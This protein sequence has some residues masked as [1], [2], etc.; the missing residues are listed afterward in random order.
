MLIASA[1]VQVKRPGNFRGAQAGGV[2]R[3]LL[4]VEH[5]IAAVAKKLHQIRQ[6]HFRSV[7]LAEKHRFRGE[8][9][10]DAHA[11]GATAKLAGVP[12]F[13]AVGVA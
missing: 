1:S 6:C 7:A 5:P 8:E 13:H 10:A 12:G 4:D 3:E 9:T 11:V 2:G